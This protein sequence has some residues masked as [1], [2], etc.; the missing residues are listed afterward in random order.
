M[1][2][3]ITVTYYG[4]EGTGPTVTAAKHNAGRKIDEMLKGDY[5]PRLIQ[6]R[7]ITIVLFRDPFR[8]WVYSSIENLAGMTAD[9]SA[10]TKQLRSSSASGDDYETEYN[11]ALF[12]LAQITWQHEDGI[13]PPD[14]LNITLQREYREYFRWQMGYKFLQAQGMEDQAIR[15]RLI[16]NGRDLD[17]P[18]CHTCERKASAKNNGAWECVNCTVACHTINNHQQ[19]AAQV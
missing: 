16:T 1:S 15:E 3:T 9:G 12:H 19:D 10:L 14:F 7:H 4:V 8:G 18:I 5:T 2:K 13:C 11:R 6:Y 17:L